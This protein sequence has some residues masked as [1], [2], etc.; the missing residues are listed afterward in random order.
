MTLGINHLGRDPNGL[1]Q[2]KF[3]EAYHKLDT[4]Y[5]NLAFLLNLESNLDLIEAV[6]GISQAITSVAQVKDEIQ[7]IY[8]ELDRILASYGDSFKNPMDYGAV[9]DGITDDTNAIQSV[10]NLGGIIKFPRG[11]TFLVSG[12]D[13]KIDNTVLVGSGS[14]SILK[15]K[16]GSN[17][18][19]L[20][21]GKL[22]GFL[23]NT[24]IY[25]LYLDGNRLNQT[26]GTKVDCINL[27]RTL[28]TRIH[29]CELFN[30]YHDGVRI[31]GAGSALS[32]DTWVVD[33]KIYDCGEYGIKLGEN[34]GTLLAS[35]NI[36]GPVT[37][38]IS[39]KNCIYIDNVDAR[40]IGN[41]CFSGKEGNLVVTSSANNAQI[42]DN[43]FE[44]ARNHGVI[45]IGA[46]NATLK[47]NLI[48]KSGRSN[49]PSTAN[50]Y[51][52]LYMRRNDVG[53]KCTN[54]IIVGNNIH[55][56]NVMENGILLQKYG[57]EILDGSIS[58]EKSV[59]TNNAL[60]GNQTGGINAKYIEGVVIKD[61]TPID[62]YRAMDLHY[63]DIFANTDVTKVLSIG[64]K[65]TI[66]GFMNGVIAIFDVE[67]GYNGFGQ[68]Q[69]NGYI[70]C[71]HLIISKTATAVEGSYYTAEL[72]NLS[73]TLIKPTVTIN[74]VVDN[75]TDL[76]LTLTVTAKRGIYIN[77]KQKFDM[78]PKSYIVVEQVFDPIKSYTLLGGQSNAENLF[79]QA[80]NEFK[81]STYNIA[82][83]QF[84]NGASIGTA[85]LTSNGG[86]WYNNSTDQLE[87]LAWLK[88]FNAIKNNQTI[89][90]SKI[91]N[92]HWDQGESDFVKT[93]KAD[94]NEG[95][96]AIF[97]QSQVLLPGIPIYITIPNGTSNTGSNAFD[98]TTQ[99]ESVQNVREIYFSII[100]DLDY[101]FKGA[102]RFDLPM[103]DNVH[104]T[105]A[106]YKQLAERVAHI[107]NGGGIGPEVTNVVLSG[108]TLTITIT[109][110]GGTDITPS[111]DIQ[112][113]H[114]RDNN[115]PIALS[116]VN[117]VN[118]TTITATLASAPTSNNKVLYYI[119]GDRGVG[120]IDLTKVCRDNHALAM[121]LRAMKWIII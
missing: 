111:T 98:G 96:R 58:I 120:L 93:F 54:C 105:V 43:H 69:A 4:L 28:N 61:N 9:G 59:I 77:S 52:G 6:L 18:S 73:G 103:A 75:E 26:A 17:R 110:N 114:F 50:Q 35:G 57:I 91:K 85:I 2:I 41:H 112:G 86:R 10:L 99:N 119:Y 23:F 113:F 25:D 78:I 49:S 29:N 3:N 19:L 100:D 64:V 109:H 15:L 20:G 55:S 46:K 27:Y 82:G 63:Y 62:E 8:N 66:G 107:L 37:E 74:K 84:I 42:L 83:Y 79:F 48:V 90:L 12:V 71:Y 32:L 97:A 21:N 76:L 51:S 117:R 1:I 115:V 53:V 65:T 31:E 7:A 40:I 108:T 67:I 94:H 47:G 34:S 68:A 106:G 87:G 56:E 118:A 72:V 102:E 22:T 16:N 38:G 44:S 30:A 33:C 39:P 36:I 14:G 121:P 95:L 92:I 116:N 45:L 81:N 104:L 89:T 11:K 70:G 60:N 13:F 80:I 24:R 101:V 5:Q 88:Y